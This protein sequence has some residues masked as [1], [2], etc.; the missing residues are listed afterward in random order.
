MD[1]INMHV[2]GDSV[3]AYYEKPASEIFRAASPKKLSPKLQAGFR[4]LYSR[5]NP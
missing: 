1:F 2:K 5:R 3:F 4:R